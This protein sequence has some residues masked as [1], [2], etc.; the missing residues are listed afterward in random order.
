MQAPPPLSSDAALFLDFDGTLVAI[1]ETPEAIEV[2]PTLVPLLIELHELLAGAVAVVSG[3]Q[4][5]MLDRFLA[6]M[7]LPAAGE[8]GVQR[9]DAEGRMQEQT[10]PDLGFVLDACNALAQDHAGLLVERKHA[11][12][13][14]HYRLAPQLEPL[15][16]EALEALL[17]DQL[18]LELLHGK[19]VFEV[20]PAGMNKG[21]AIDAFL[22]EKP[23]AGRRA[24]FA[25]DDT[26]DE[27]GFA[28]VQRYPGGVAIKVGS[29]PS[30]ALHRLSG[31]LAVHEW[32]RGLR[33]RLVAQKQ[34][35]S[36]AR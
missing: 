14:L 11:G 36:S 9:R 6:P 5:D 20:K 8:H 19:C 21:I 7:R 4:I 12:V 1:A 26:T 24:V 34:K 10:P 17:A 15:C 3:R 16:R 2:P 25:G 30:Q 29:G 27:T 18:H 32:L 31:P 23:F 22:Q 28:V 35:R 13:A 33:D